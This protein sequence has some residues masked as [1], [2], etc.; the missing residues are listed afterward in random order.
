[1]SVCLVYILC[2]AKHIK[3]GKWEVTGI[4]KGTYGTASLYISTSLGPSAPLPDFLAI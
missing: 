3:V 2:Y 1:M 4:L